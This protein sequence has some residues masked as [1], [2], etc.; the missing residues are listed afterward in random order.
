MARRR[1]PDST[2][3]RRRRPDSTMAKERGINVQTTIHKALLRKLKIKD[4]NSYVPE[5]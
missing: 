1:K 4:E 5:G 3:A 2:M